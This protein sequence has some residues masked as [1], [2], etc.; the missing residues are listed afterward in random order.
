M[1]QLI[2][3]AQKGNIISDVSALI[4]YNNWG[5]P[6]YTNKGSFNTA[7]KFA[8][9]NKADEF[10]W[11]NNRYHTNKD[12]EPL[13]G[14]S[15]TNK[16]L[17]FSPE[18]VKMA[19]R[20]RKPNTVEIDNSIYRANYRPSTKTITYS[21]G[22]IDSYNAELSHHKRQSDAQN[23]YAYE[24]MKYGDSKNGSQGVYNTKGTLEYDTHR[25]TEPALAM[26]LQGNFSP[27]DVK[28]I[29]RYVGAK[30][31]GILQEE[32]Y[33][34]I[35]NKYYN[36]N[37]VKE[38]RKE[39]N[40]DNYENQYNYDQDLKYDNLVYPIGSVMAPYYISALANDPNIGLSSLVNNLQGH[41]YSDKELTDLDINKFDVRKLQTDLFNKGYDLQLVKKERD[42]WYNW[43]FDG[44]LGKETMNALMDYRAKH[45]PK[46]ISGIPTKS[47]LALPNVQ[48]S[49]NTKI[50]QR[51]LPTEPFVP[52]DHDKYSVDPELVKE[53]KNHK[54]LVRKPVKTLIKNSNAKTY[55]DFINKNKYSLMRLNFK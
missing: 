8:K 7:F 35:V 44:I 30:E 48:V 41:S 22:N 13:T 39:A 45:T 27:E 50:T 26:M 19:N 23:K 53:V 6:D 5:V 36:Y 37:K 29:Q 42:G 12:N 14:N 1:A 25:L 32:T 46:T 31:D 17:S 9:D 38:F 15:E 33:R 18:Y 55:V 49:D 21:N 34:K 11:N 43:E 4:N 40:V 28:K 3:K 10:M 20:G 52:Y 2:K 54:S 16:R 51:E 47:Y 24:F